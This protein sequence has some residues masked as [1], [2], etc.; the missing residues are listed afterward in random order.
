MSAYSDG[1][2]GW[3]EANRDYLVAVLNLLRTRIRSG[4]ELL[5]RTTVTGAASRLSAPAALDTLTQG[6]GLTE[7]ERDVLVLAAGPDLVA[8]TADELASAFGTPRITFAAAMSLLPQA[9]WSAMTPDAP[10]RRWKLLRLAEPQSPSHSPLL[11]DERVLHHLVGAGYLACE[12]AA[13]SR[14]RSAPADLPPSLRTAAA[15]VACRWAEHRT[16]LLH[17]PQP[18]NVLAAAVGAATAKGLSLREISAADLPGETAARHRM[19]RLMERETVLDGCAW[20]LDVTDAT[21][22]DLARCARSLYAVAAPV[23]LLAGADAPAVAD[24]VPVEVPRLGLDERRHLF[25]DALTQPDPLADTAAGVFD[26]PLPHI[27][28]VVQEVSTGVPLWAACRTRARRTFGGLA[29]VLHPQANW[30]DLV[31]PTAQLD[32]L[33]AL[34]GRARHRVTVLHDWG[35]AGRSARGLGTTALFAGGSGTGKTFAAE[36]IAHDLALDLVQVDAAT[37][38][39]KYIGETQKN[40]R[41]L[42]DEAEDGGVVLLFD[43]ADA[44]FGRRTEVRDSHDRYS[45]QEVGYLLQRLETFRGLAILTTNARSALDPAFMRRLSAVISFP[46]PD[47]AA[48]EALWRRAFPPGTP[49]HDI[50]TAELAVRDLSGGAIASIALSSAYL[51]ATDGGVVT[52]RH[53]SDALRWE[54]AKSGRLPSG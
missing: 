10:L 20:A 34:A 36:V 45:N 42:F 5:D 41:R 24:V 47:L 6:F 49:L 14:L 35:F 8:E 43:E 51:A 4:G 7:F 40:L 11:V 50:D 17:G 2:G 21:G 9:H 38:V 46:Y 48:R 22:E 25:R 27:G 53:L 44:L 26:L 31:L 13:L 33:R 1:D 37:V 28:D 15:T 29:R 32:Q 39:N 19:V 3:A 54:L 52:P 30:D 18:D 16:V 23:V 12:L